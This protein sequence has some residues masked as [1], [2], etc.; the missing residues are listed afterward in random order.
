M[1]SVQAWLRSQEEQRCEKFATG[2]I[3]GTFDR[4]NVNMNTQIV[5]ARQRC[6]A[7]KVWDE[8]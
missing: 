2:L 3:A 6:E 4:L 5:E 8:F 1:L 7:I